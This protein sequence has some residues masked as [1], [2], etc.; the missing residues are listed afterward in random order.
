MKRKGGSS[1]PGTESSPQPFCGRANRRP[2]EPSQLFGGGRGARGS[3]LLFG[4]IFHVGR[5]QVFLADLGINIRE[6][7]KIAKSEGCMGKNTFFYPHTVP[8]GGLFLCTAVS[9]E[10][11]LVHRV[12]LCL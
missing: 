7:I 6:G 12:S 9:V 3:R 10:L 5:L 4:C 1:G 2:D 11:D 8:L